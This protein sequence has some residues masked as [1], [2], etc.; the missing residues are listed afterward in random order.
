MRIVRVAEMANSISLSFTGS[1]AGCP[2]SAQDLNNGQ[3]STEEEKEDL[4]PVQPQQA[5]KMTKLIH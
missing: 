1:K 4:H 3:V 2:A 5:A